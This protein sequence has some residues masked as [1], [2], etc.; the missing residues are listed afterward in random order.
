MFAY[1]ICSGFEKAGIIPF[2]PDRLLK[3]CPGTEGAVE[4]RQKKKSEYSEEILTDTQNV[5][6]SLPVC[7]EL[8]SA[9][10]KN[11]CFNEVLRK[12]MIFMM[13]TILA[14][15]KAIIRYFTK[16]SIFQTK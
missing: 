13:R 7:L 4:I 2:N 15:W 3:R 10:I 14:G 8:M 1:K 9:L 16:S 11:I 6:S 5:Q 12:G